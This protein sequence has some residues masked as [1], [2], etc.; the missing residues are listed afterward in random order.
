[1]STTRARGLAVL[2]TLLVGGCTGALTDPGAD[3]STDGSRDA[4]RAIDAAEDFDATRDAASADVGTDAAVT[5]PCETALFCEPFEGYTETTLTDGQRFGP[6]RAALRTP[7]GAMDLDGTHTVSGDAALHMRIEAGTTAGGR[8]FTEGALPILA[9]NPTHIYGRMMMYIE[10]NGTSVHWTFFG[11]SGDAEASSPVAGRRA[12]YLI[13]SLPR[14]G[15]NTYSF[16]DGLEASD[17]DPFHDCWFQS[18]EPMPSSRWTCIAFEMDGVGRHLRLTTDGAA[19]PIMSLDDHGQGCVGDVVPGDSPWYGPEIDQLY[20]G[21]WSF[22]DMD[23][24][25]EVWIDD[26]IVDTSPVP[27]P[28][29]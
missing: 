9:G 25:L 3:G 11:A 10:P 26:L 8:L 18:M 19:D 23:A 20:V 5:D 14:S 2:G 4:A 22:H 12:T 6:W 21:A 28:A 16:V 24:P 29:P 13:S 1:M 15:V 7:G 27:C 17:P